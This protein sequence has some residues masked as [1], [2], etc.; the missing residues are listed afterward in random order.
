[1][2]LARVHSHADLSAREIITLS[3]DRS[4]A[5][6]QADKLDAMSAAD[7]QALPL[8]GLP[9]S[10]KECVKVTTIMMTSANKRNARE[11]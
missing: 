10:L 2:V 9:V 1:M 3:A 7:R 6:E 4:E 11:Y 8:F 5:L